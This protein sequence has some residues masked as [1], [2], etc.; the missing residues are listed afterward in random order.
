VSAW[1]DRQIAEWAEEYGIFPYNSK[2]VN[3]ASIDLCFSGKAKISTTRGFDELPFGNLTLRRGEFYLADTLEEICMPPN[4]AGKL[5]VK[6][7]P[8]RL[9]LNH[10][11]AGWFEPEFT[12]TATL[13]IYLLARKPYTIAVGQP[14]VQMALFDIEPPAVSYRITGRYNGQ[15]GPTEA[16]NERDKS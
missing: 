4:A 6:S 14:I 11:N 3:T 7:T 2:L 1:N 12:G 16:R 5:M 9:G 8:A 15:S 13:E 10:S